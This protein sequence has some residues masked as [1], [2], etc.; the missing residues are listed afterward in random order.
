MDFTYS[1]LLIMLYEFL[2]WPCTFSSFLFFV[3]FFRGENIKDTR[4]FEGLKK[5]TNIYSS[6]VI[7]TNIELNIKTKDFLHFILVKFHV[8]K[9]IQKKISNPSKC[10]I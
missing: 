6:S 1:V 9:Y 3:F 4:A 2:P 5:K 8:S 7:K 10:A